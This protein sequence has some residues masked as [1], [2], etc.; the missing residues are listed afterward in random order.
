[1]ALSGSYWKRTA[2]LRLRRATDKTLGL[3][4]AGGLKAIRLTDPNKLGDFAS[5]AMRRIGPKRREH[6]IGRENLKMAFPEKSPE[7]IEQILEGVWDNLGRVAAEIAHLDRLWD[8]DLTR[9]T[10]GRML[11]SDES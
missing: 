7:E 11:D 9:K 4:T 10:R 2:K 5:W 6:L 8:Y 1:M 3:L